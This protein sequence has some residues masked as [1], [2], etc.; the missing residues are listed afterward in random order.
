MGPYGKGNV[1][2]K[3]QVSNTGT[4]MG[5]CREYLGGLGKKRKFN[6]KSDSADAPTIGRGQMTKY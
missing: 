3:C 2:I 6:T 5:N 1:K 4:I